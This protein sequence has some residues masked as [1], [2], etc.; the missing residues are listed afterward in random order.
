MEEVARSYPHL[1]TLESIGRSYENRD[2]KLVRISTDTGSS[3]RKPTIFIDAGIHAREWIAPAQAIYL[4]FQLVENYSVNSALLRNVDFVILPLVNPDGYEF[5]RTNTRLWRKTRSPGSLCVGCDGNRNFDYYWMFAGASSSQCSETYAGKN[6]FSEIETRNLRDAILR[7][8][9]V[10]AYLTF[11]SYGNYFL[12]PWGWS[13]ALPDNWQELQSLGDQAAAAI[14]AVAGT[15]Y[16]VG[17]STNV[18]YEAAGASDDWA[19]GVA[20]IPIVYTI[21]L[22]GGGTYGFDLPANR[23]LSVVQETFEGVKVVVNYVGNR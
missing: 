16:T 2:T 3:I 23:I 11:H 18:L 9:A 13:P 5:S 21:E 12:Y 1:V 15:R 19:M 22:P 17:S 6:A 7:E 10:V 8:P 4:I 20:K 14:R